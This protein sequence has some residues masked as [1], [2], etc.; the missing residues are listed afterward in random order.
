MEQ[1]AADIIEA[2]GIGGRKEVCSVGGKESVQQTNF[3]KD[4]LAILA[5]EIECILS[6]NRNEQFLRKLLTRAVILEKLLRK[7]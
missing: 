2:A 5:E 1:E 3:E 7:V 4:C 6:R